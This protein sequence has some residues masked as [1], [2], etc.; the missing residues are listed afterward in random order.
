MG[1]HLS[2]CRCAARVQ[3]IAH[4]GLNDRFR[5]YRYEAGQRF[6]PHVDVRTRIPEGETRASLMIH[7]NDRF[8]GGETRFFEEKDKRSRCGEG[9]GRKF[10]NRV[11][12]A[13][14]PAI[15]SVVVV[16]HLLLHEDSEVTAGVKYAVRSD[17][18]YVP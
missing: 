9:R 11:R 4:E 13:L 8:E 6:F 16:D 18:V 15:G 5:V 14:R 3:R 12:F 10:N 1:A 7:L 17:L 2:A